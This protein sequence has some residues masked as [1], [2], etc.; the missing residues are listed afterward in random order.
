MDAPIPV[1]FV[2]LWVLCNIYYDHTTIGT[3]RI[4]SG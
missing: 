3:S 1:V 2:L 4:D